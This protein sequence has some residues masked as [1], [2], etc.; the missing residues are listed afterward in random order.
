M[1]RLL[2]PR[3][4]TVNPDLTASALGPLRHTRHGI[5][6]ANLGLLRTHGVQIGRAQQAVM[7]AG[8]APRG[9]PPLQA[10]HT[11]STVDPVGVVVTIDIVLW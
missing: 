2:L 9:M 7:C 4:S 6:R 5:Y 10:K 3:T 1:A 8:R 11:S